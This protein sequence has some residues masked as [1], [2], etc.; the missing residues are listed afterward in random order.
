MRPRRQAGADR[1]LPGLQRQGHDRQPRHQ[2]F[3]PR[4][5]LTP[6]YEVIVVNDGSTDATARDRSTSSR[7]PTR[8]CAWFTTREPRLRRRAA[9]RLR[10]ATK[11]L[12]FYT[13]GDAQ[14]DPAELAAL[15]AA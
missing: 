1:L 11:E 7:G 10:A 6:D 4:R 9:Q 13:D 2:P 8:R 12:I 5:E 15:W 14:Y 3:S